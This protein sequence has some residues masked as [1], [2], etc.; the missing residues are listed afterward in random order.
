MESLVFETESTIFQDEFVAK[1]MTRASLE[2]N[3]IGY[4]E[5]IMIQITYY[6]ERGECWS[7]VEANEGKGKLFTEEEREGRVGAVRLEVIKIQ[8]N[9]KLFK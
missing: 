7:D 9:I 3:E 8:N 2:L 6:V 5:W 4:W 1:D